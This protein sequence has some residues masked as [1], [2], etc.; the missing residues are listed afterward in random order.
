VSAAA[1]LS[2]SARQAC[3]GDRGLSR[4]LSGEVY[5]LNEAFRTAEKSLSTALEL[6][7]NSRGGNAPMTSRR[8]ETTAL[9]NDKSDVANR[10]F[11]MDGKALRAEQGA[12]GSAGAAPA[13][14][15]AADKTAAIEVKELTKIFGGGEDR[16]TAL[17]A[18]QRGGRGGADGLSR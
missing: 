8:G 1:R 12:S 18:V 15:T 11:A 17:D 14:K 6:R 16:V 3:D 7:S 10:G 4:W 9:P 13:D 5:S 2:L